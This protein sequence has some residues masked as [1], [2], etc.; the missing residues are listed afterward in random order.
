MAG[1][2]DIGELLGQTPG[3]C[4]GRVCIAGTGVSVR[5]I[6]GWYKQ[7]L[8]PRSRL[9]A[10]STAKTVPRPVSATFVRPF[11]RAVR[12]GPVLG[13]A[14]IKR[15]ANTDAHERKIDPTP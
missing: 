9:Y 15:T 8:T 3:V 11:I 10:R 5:R 14:R 4:G 7:G 13:P 2:S 1:L 6:V 12:K